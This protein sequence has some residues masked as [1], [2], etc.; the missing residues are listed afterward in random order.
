MIFSSVMVPMLSIESDIAGAIAKQVK[1]SKE[2]F[3]I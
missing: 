1:A 3:G 2:Q